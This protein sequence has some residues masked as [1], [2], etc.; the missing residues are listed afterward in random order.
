M[1]FKHMDQKY[2]VDC[3]AFL[4]NSQGLRCKVCQREHTKKQAA[5]RSSTTKG[6]PKPASTLGDLN[7]KEDS[8]RLTGLASH[9]PSASRFQR[10]RTLC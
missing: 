5:S 1:A 8:G 7:E 3:D 2:C 10:G 6:N 9:P 4:P